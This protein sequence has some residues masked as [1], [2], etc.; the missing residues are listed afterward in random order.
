MVPEGGES[1]G[2]NREWFANL[3]V[4]T[5]YSWFRSP[6]RAVWGRNQEY[7]YARSNAS[8]QRRRGGADEHV[9]H[10]W[11]PYCLPQPAARFSAHVTD[12]MT[13]YSEG[14]RLL[15]PSSSKT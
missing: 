7:L 6:R 4:L 9:N 5:G 12:V 11:P 10:H 15:C 8:Q 1:P 3:P 13:S 2:G 14:Y